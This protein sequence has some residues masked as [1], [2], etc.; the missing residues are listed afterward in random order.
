MD[1]TV[2]WPSSSLRRSGRASFRAHRH[3]AFS[4][5]IRE[6]LPKAP[7]VHADRMRQIAQADGFEQIGRPCNPPPAGGAA[8]A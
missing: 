2:P 4:T 3:R 8:H 7:R 6:G 1:S 5:V